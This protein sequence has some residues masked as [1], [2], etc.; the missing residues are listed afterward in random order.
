MFINFKLFLIKMVNLGPVFKKDLDCSKQMIEG[1]LDISLGNLKAYPL[2]AYG[3]CEF[4]Y[5]KEFSIIENIKDFFE[6][7]IDYFEMGMKDTNSI[8]KAGNTGVYY[9]KDCFTQIF[10]QDD[11]KK[12]LFH[13]LYHI[14]L[15]K[16][17][18]FEDIYCEEFEFMVP[19]LLDESFAELMAINMIKETGI[20]IKSKN[21]DTE[22]AWLNY[23]LS[24]AN[25]ENPKEIADFVIRCDADKEDYLDSYLRFR[26]QYSIR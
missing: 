17:A 10:S 14:A 8:A 6:D 5:D 1:Q 21:L 12:I 16:Y 25:I 26:K 24:K 18:G 11:A 4:R 7:T 2:W 15:A 19:E 20:D 9:A 3:I 13:E 22:V 23:E